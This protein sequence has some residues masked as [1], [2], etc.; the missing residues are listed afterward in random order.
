MIQWAF[1][2]DKVAGYEIYPSAII[3]QKAK[4]LCKITAL[5]IAQ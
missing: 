3:N 2:H 5:D 1:S 4:K